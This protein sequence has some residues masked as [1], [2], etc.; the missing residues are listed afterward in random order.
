MGE[1]VWM[2]DVWAASEPD[3]E[4]IS[5]PARAEL[6]ARAE[7]AEAATQ[8]VRALATGWASDPGFGEI[9]FNDA[10]EAILAALDSTDPVEAAPS[11]ARYAPNGLRTD[12]HVRVAWV[13]TLGDSPAEPHSI[14]EIMPSDSGLPVDGEERTNG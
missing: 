1:H 12:G 9:F 5:K 14:A 11:G 13:P 7:R 10:A 3:Y 8:R 4:Y 2:R 6:T